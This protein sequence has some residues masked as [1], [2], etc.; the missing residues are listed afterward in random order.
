MKW[1]CGEWWVGDNVS[2]SLP[3]RLESWFLTWLDPL[4]G[5]LSL[6]LRLTNLPVS[7][8]APC[9]FTKCVQIPPTNWEFSEE[10]SGT[11]EAEPETR[12]MCK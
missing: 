8:S 10:P 1:G 4:W 7:L 6:C 11:T 12:I 3:V 5:D 2:F 9:D